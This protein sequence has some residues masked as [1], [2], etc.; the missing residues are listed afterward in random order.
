MVGMVGSGN[1]TATTALQNL[2]IAFNSVNKTL[3]YINGQFTS[4]TY[5]AAG[6]STVRIFHGR[7]RVVSV[8]VVATGGDL[9]L[10]DSSVSSI[11]PA[12]SLKFKLDSSAA[13]GVHL[14][15]VEFTNGI[16]LDVNAP[17]EANITYSVY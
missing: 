6:L 11:T 14:V 10:Y 13:L 7:C 17:I 4:D 1:D 8:T 9:S 3:Q 5:P 15:G 16:V 12:S 2:V